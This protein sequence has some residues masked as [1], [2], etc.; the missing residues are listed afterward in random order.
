MNPLLSAISRYIRRPLNNRASIRRGQRK[1]AQ[2]TVK[3]WLDRLEERC[4]LSYSVSNLDTLGVHGFVTGMNASGQVCIEPAFSGDSSVWDSS[5]GVQDLGNLGGGSSIAWAINDSEQVVGWSYTNRV[6]YNFHAFVWDSSH[7]MQDLGTF[8]GLKSLALDINNSGQV[9]GGSFT[10]SNDE[11]AFVWDSSHGMQDLGTLGGSFSEARGIN[12]Y[13]QVVGDAQTAS[14]AVHAFVWDSSHGMQDLGTLGGSSYANDINNSG[15]VVGYS[16]TTGG[17]YHAFVWDS[18]HGMQ[19]LGTLGGSSSSAGRINDSGQVVGQ[20]DTASGDEHAFIWD[21]SH[22]MQDLLG[23]VGGTECL[24]QDIND[25]GQVVGNAYFAGNFPLP[26]LASPTANSPVFGALSPPTIVY[27]SA[28][29][30][31]GHLADGSL[32]PPVG[33]TV[34]VTLNG[35]TQNA[36]LDGSGN[37]STTFSTGSLQ[38][39][40]AFAVSYIYYGDSTFGAVGGSSTLTITQDATATTVSSSLNSV[41]ALQPVTFTATVSASAPGAGTPTGS[42]DFMDSASGTDLGT[43]SLS[44]GSAS[45][46][47]SSLLEDSSLPGDT[48]HSIVATYEGDKNFLTSNNS[49]APVSL[50]VTDV[51]PTVAIINQ[52]PTDASNNPTAPVGTLLSFGGS[53]SDSPVE[54][55]GLTSSDAISWSV[56]L[57]GQPYSLPVSVSTNGPTFSFTPTTVGTYVVSLTVADP[58]G[59][60][61]TAQQTLDIT[62]MDG[63][64]LQNLINF[65]AN[66]ANLGFSY[67]D[68]ATTPVTLTVQADPTQENAAVAALNSVIQPQV[69]DNYNGAFALVDVNVTLNLTSGNYSDLDFSLQPPAVDNDVG[70]LAYITVI[71]NGVNGSTTVVGNSPALTV[72]SGNVSVNN[73]TFTTATNSPTILV[74]GGSLALRSDVVQESTGFADAAIAVTGGSVDLGS[75]TDPG[76]NTINVNGSGQLVQA[77]GP[78][79]VSAEGDTFQINGTA[80][81]P[82]TSTTLTSSA[83]TTFFNQ[84]VTLTATVAALTPNTGTP[85]GTVSFFDLTSG[86]ALGSVRLSSGVAKFTSSSL[87]PGSHNILA[88]YSGD[89]NFISSSSSLVQTVSS[90]SGFLP[91]LSNGLAYAVNRTIPIK[92]SLTDANGK[93]ITSL[94]A[95]SSLQT[96]PIVNGVPG[97]PFNPAS[98]N[99]QGLQ[100]SGGQYLFNWQTKG[101]AAGSYQ[102]VLTLADG[103]TQTKTIQLTAGGSAA[104]LVTDGSVGTST[105][106]ALLGGEADLYVDNSNGDLTSDELARIQDAVTAIDAVI[107]PY[108]VTILE[109]TDPTLAN[110]ILTMNT[111]S[112]LGGVAQGVLGCTDDADQVTMIQ[113]W[114]WYAG[115]DPT[116][117]GAGQYDFETAVMHELGHVL[118]LG[119]NSSS[120]SVMYASLATGTAN[121]VLTTADLSVPDSDSGPCALHAAPAAAMTSTSTS[122][123]MPL[124]S[125][126]SV[127]SSGIPIS[128]AEQLFADF[129][130]LNAMRNANQPASSLSPALW[131]S[132]DALILQRLDALL[133]MEAGAMGVTKDTLLNDFL[134]ARSSSF[135]SV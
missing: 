44:G 89:S 118:G 106:G 134:F 5:H 52:L 91:P 130:L 15:Q 117:V 124:P 30:L 21:S 95:V 35:V 71:V 34:S 27:G 2:Q 56:T 79:T 4:L 122:P 14:G 82:L 116:Q 99:N 120:T 40:S 13:G 51:P 111:T 63:N 125:N 133:S 36:A 100:Y 90:F 62:S 129:I 45:L 113:G 127:P 108:G 78:G 42:V 97:S 98:T 131:Q 3:L 50:V 135:S 8:G 105:A 19:D 86:T 132:M 24:A 93:A 69:Y 119:H 104:G 107:A 121:R 49:A 32:T 115:A 75:T 41:V 110:V 16:Y 31:S 7:G 101:L 61:A 25:S 47:V 10:A 66:S 23:T 92:F 22:G 55:R 59:G 18:S 64:S 6:I 123:S 46:T 126:P 9:V 57:N 48:P 58:D 128:A 68:G 87:T 80:A 103:T 60:T 114:S 88:V 102:I 37:F 11:H 26:F 83:N 76:N 96:A 73:V 43:V 85:T 70:G 54:N 53:F 29:T 65:E 94:S 109:V 84:S 77:S 12:D 20:S 17:N 38:A 112:S 39:G 1:V 74:T 81:H 72:T 67:W 33:E 28:T